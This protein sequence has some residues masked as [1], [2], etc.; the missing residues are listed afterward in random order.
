MEYELEI[1]S[2]FDEVFGMSP[3]KI[4]ARKLYCVGITSKG[5]NDFFQ[6][7][8]GQIIPSDQQCNVMNELINIEKSKTS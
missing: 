3:Y 8:R 5:L 4:A 2:V 1:E 7:K 6:T